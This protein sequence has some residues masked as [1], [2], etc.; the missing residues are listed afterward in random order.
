MDSP[1]FPLSGWLGPAPPRRVRVRRLALI[2]SLLAVFLPAFGL[3]ARAVMVPDLGQV[4]DGFAVP[5]AAEAGAFMMAGIG[6]LLYLYRF[7]SAR[8]VSVVQTIGS[9]IALFGLITLVMQV[10]SPSSS[11][12]PLL[13]SGVSPDGGERVP[14]ISSLLFMGLGL[15]LTL[16]PYETRRG[17]RPAQYCALS[18]VFFGGI[19]A[20][21]YLYDVRALYAV[22]PYGAVGLFSALLSIIVGVALLCVHPAAG[23]MRTLTSPD[24]GG[25]LLRR[26]LPFAIGLPLLG[27]WLRIL[28]ERQGWYRF[29]FGVAAS[30][31]L[32]LLLLLAC[33]WYVANYANRIDRERRRVLR[34]LADHQARLHLAVA[35]ARIGYWNWIE[36]GDTVELDRT[37]EMLMGL[38][39][40][41]S[42][43]LEGWL[44]AIH[45]DD[46][47]AVKEAIS[48]SCRTRQPFEVECRP[49]RSTTSAGWVSLRGDPTSGPSAAVH[50]HGVMIDVSE[51]R[52]AQEALRENQ[53]RLRSIVQSAMD[54]IITVGEDQ[55]IVLFNAAAERLFQCRAADVVGTPVERFIPERF[56]AA[57]RAHMIGFQH[58]GVSARQMGGPGNVSGLRTDGKEFPIEASISKVAVGGQTLCTVILR[59]ITERQRSEEAIREREARFRTMAD[60]AP[61]MIWVADP[62]GS[63][64]YLNRQ[65]YEFTGLTE[66]TGIGTAWLEAIH[67]LDRMILTRA[68]RAAAGRPR[69]ERLE[70]RLRR[71]DGEYR[72]ALTSLLPLHDERGAVS[73]FIGSSIDITERKEAEQTLRRSADDLERQVAERTA[74]LSRSQERLRALT[75]ELTRTE[76]Q[77]RRRIAGELH[78][79]LAQ[80]LVVARLKLAQIR[81]IVQDAPSHS[82]VGDMERILDEALTYTRSLVAELYPQV[83]YHLGLPAALRWLG[84]QMAHHALA[85]RTVAT[86][87]ESLKLTDDVAINLFQSVRELLF[88]VVKHAD[89]PEA[90]VTL[91]TPGGSELVITVADRG[92]GFNPGRLEQ[93]VGTTHNFGLFS[94]RERLESIGGR[95]TIESR[96]GGGTRVTLSLPLPKHEAPVP[97]ER[98]TAPDHPGGGHPLADSRRYRVLLADDHAMVRQGIRALLERQETLVII[99][100]APDGARAVELADALIPD[101]VVIDA[102]MPHMDGIEATRR[103]KARHPDTVVI[104]VSVQSATQVAESMLSAGASAY[105]TKE[106]A[107]EQ[108]YEAIVNA[109]AHGSQDVDHA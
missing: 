26:L 107:G 62:T 100:E 67:P 79:Y 46:Q 37:S 61:V 48:E 53:E 70:Y 21:G 28:G 42:G 22:G 93:T 45:R 64:S 105:L 78:D 32:V 72:W 24:L 59:D 27:G 7:S 44:G 74:A 82:V 11:A 51:R 77:E 38:P 30:I 65:W 6:L 12:E 104:G 5:H 55:R 89:C 69:L 17:R 75:R 101:V 57:H 94:I 56:R 95:M 92:R 34:A 41:F 98:Q 81:P 31:G 68:F 10:W 108:L 25:A 43:T 9:M 58:G 14:L 47:A 54:A 3:A 20:T 8:C 85:V 36:A 99:G 71:R 19:T 4:L 52:S 50:I 66:K 1:H 84:E 97:T 39:A 106:S 88:N 60:S 33:L 73:G 96:A 40:G 23:F 86:G 15:A 87:V 90:T 49:A 18:A 103:I 63:S 29:S 16:L 2:G 13:F 102:N 35:A 83:L 91:G 80:L 76:H 109:L